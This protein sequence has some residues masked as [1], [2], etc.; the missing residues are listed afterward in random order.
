M[1]VDFKILLDHSSLA[2]SYMALRSALNTGEDL[3][4]ESIN[5]YHA[6]SMQILTKYLATL[7]IC[8]FKEL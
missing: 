1:S 3:V 5:K 6:N 2:L 4:N 8:E 7:S